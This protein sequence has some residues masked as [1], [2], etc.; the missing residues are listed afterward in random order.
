MLQVSLAQPQEHLRRE[1]RRLRECHPHVVG[2]L[3]E[4]ASQQPFPRR[5]RQLLV[6]ELE[7]AEHRRARPLR[8]QPGGADQR[9]VVGR[10]RPCLEET[11]QD[12]FLVDVD[13]RG[14]IGLRQTEDLVDGGQQ[15]GPRTGRSLEL[16]EGAVG[17]RARFVREVL[18]RPL[19]AQQPFGRRALDRVCRDAAFKERRQHL[20]R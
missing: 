17:A 20:H 3:L 4:I 7:P 16:G 18:V 8:H 1:V 11:L 14:R 10:H 13:R 19:E 6:L 9:V 2:E 12:P 5:L 15:L